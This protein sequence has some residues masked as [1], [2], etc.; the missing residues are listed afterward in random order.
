VIQPTATPTD[1]VMTAEN[2]R[3]LLTSGRVA[4]TAFVDDD[5]RPGL[6][7]MNYMLPGQHVLL[8]TSAD[9]RLALQTSG[10]PIDALL[11]VDSSS[12]AGRFGW[13][14][15]VTGSLSRDDSVAPHDRPAPWRRGATGVALRL[16]VEELTGRRVDSSRT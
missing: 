8:Q 1:S 7:V 15:I 2:C 10:G 4:R 14:V 6:V 16:T 11:E 9:T 12:A 5:G 3:Q 13:S